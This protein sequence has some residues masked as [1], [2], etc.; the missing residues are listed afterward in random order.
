MVIEDSLGCEVTV[1]ALVGQPDELLYSTY[2]VIGETCFGACDGEIWVDIEG[3]TAPYCYDEAQSNTTPPF[4][5]PVQLVNDSIIADLCAD[6]SPYPNPYTIFIT[7][8]NN[9]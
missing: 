3:G 2:N 9:C 8:A 1:N 4:A 6:N 5:N 7:D